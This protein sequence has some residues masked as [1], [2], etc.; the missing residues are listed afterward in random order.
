MQTLEA[1]KNYP[2]SDMAENLVGSEIIKLAAEVKQK[3]ANGKEIYNLTIGD[4]NPDVFPIPEALTSEIIAAYENGETNYP[5]APGI[6]E[7]RESVSRFIKRKGGFD[8]PADQVL[9]SGGAR[10][11]IYS[12]FRALVD[13]NDKVVFPVPSWNN[14]HYT[15]LTASQMICVETTAENNFMPTANELRPHIKE[16]SLVALCSPLNPTGTTFSK[17]ALGDICDMILEE[18]A[19]RPEGSKPVYLLYD[20]IYWMLTHGET[21]HYDPVSLRPEMTPFTVF[22]DGLSKA[23]AGTGVR[24]GW[25]YGPA[26]IINKMKA[27][28]SHMGAWAPRAEQVAVAKY[29]QKEAVVDSYLLDMKGKINDR[30]VGFYEGFQQLKSEGIKVDAIAPQAAMYLTVRINYVGS[31]KPDGSTL[32]TTQELTTYLIDEGKLALVPFSCFGASTDSN[33]YRLSVGTTRTTDIQVVVNNLREA[34]GEL[35]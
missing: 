14:N 20:Q 4:F 35:A 12:A 15:H 23:F 13:P 30:L 2:V 5:A 27:I 17:E 8:Y 22:I 26:G 1:M 16:A 29:L 9:I 31:T 32:N 10:P 34:L 25:G 7:L 24:V 21:E 18:N 28:C 33:W 6:P 19:S 11:L 3:I